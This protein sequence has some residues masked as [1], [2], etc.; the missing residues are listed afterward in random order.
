MLSETFIKVTALLFVLLYMLLYAYQYLFLTRHEKLE[1]KKEIQSS[2]LYNGKKWDLYRLGDVVRYPS[3]P[4]IIDTEE[5]L[6]KYPNSIAS[7]HIRLNPGK[8]KNQFKLLHQIIM[9]R[10]ENGTSELKM[11]PNSIALH[12]RIGDVMCAYKDIKIKNK[13]T[14]NED[15]DWWNRFIDKIK[16]NNIENIYIVAGSHTDICTLE[17]FEYIQ[18]RKQFLKNNGFNVFH[19]S[20]DPDVTITA[21]SG[22]NFF[23]SSGGGYGRLLAS[24]V[25][26]NGGTIIKP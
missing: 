9:K 1:F 8:K 22:A 2:D 16:K 17:S 7:E 12:M 3:T 13:Y 20:G 4:S 21:I 6:A 23:T 25:K 10:K 18:E 26:E 5:H 15:P 19:I 14:H 11:K 24:V